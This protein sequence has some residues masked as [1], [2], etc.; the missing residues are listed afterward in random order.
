[1]PPRRPTSSRADSSKPSGGASKNDHTEL[2]PSPYYTSRARKS[3]P[4]PPVPDEVPEDPAAEQEYYTSNHYP[5]EG[6]EGDPPEGTPVADDPRVV[7]K[8]FREMDEG[9]E[10]PIEEED[11]D[12]PDSTR[13]GPPISLLVLEG[14]DAGKK[15]RFKSVRMVVGRGK[16]V[17]LKL[18][19]QAVSRRHLELIH[20]D[21]GT[22]MR[23]LGGASGTKVNDERV[24]EKL[25]KH[26][27]EIAIGR[28]LLRFVD[29]LE[30]VKQFQAE[31]DAKEAEAKKK[32]EE[33]AKKKEEEA[34]K[35]KEEAANA[36]AAGKADVDPNDPRLKE[37][38]QIRSVPD[39]MAAVPTRRGQGKLGDKKVLYIGGAGVFAVV[40][41]VVMIIF[42]VKKDPPAPPPID[43]KEQLAIVK[44]QAARNAIR[45]G[46]YAEA[47]K[48]IEDAERLKPGIDEEGLAK[49]A[50]AEAAVMEAFQAVRALM[51]EGNYQGARQKLEE[52]PPGTTA[53]S[54]E[55]RALLEKELTEAEATFYK[56]R[57]EELLAAN[58]LE[59]LRALIP[60]LPSEAQPLY[61]D[62][63][64]ELQEARA[65]EAAEQEKLE[66]TNKVLAAK[67]AAERRA[68]F[69]AEAF[70]AV[71]RK[72]ENGD[73]ERAVLEC[74]RVIEAHKGDDEIRE[75]AKSL[76]RLI[77]QF[78]RSF[79]DAQRKVQANSMETA[80]RPLKKS[81]ELYRQIGFKGA[82]LDAIR[83]QLAEAS[84]RAGKSALARNDIA[85][86]GGHF[87]EALR[88]N[89]GDSR[90]SEAL[91]NMQGKVNELYER[92]Y[93]EKDRDPRS[94]AEKFRIV[95]DT[96]EEG[97]ELREKA[98][99]Q[100]NELSP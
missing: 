12:N 6:E 42:I 99:A 39:G 46:E 19:D 37:G 71:E 83:E 38:T 41:L 50:Q 89:P 36:S 69:I 91:T 5:S 23:D 58:D 53:K 75:R 87:R 59:G 97:S 61:R 88:L 33:A 45:D 24:E 98:Q 1:M 92:A 51:T 63:L 30:A 62:K 93:I 84:V 40:M 28:T 48:L 29:E 20:G 13:A 68:Q 32:A 76:K 94:A 66:R 21:T 8:E 81:E 85:S 54:D 57:A 67:R 14:P 34:A 52:A 22:M 10:E 11:D 79:T 4:A 55:E 72:F 25:L 27:D 47:V 73:Y 49:A 56:K 70:D 80:V 17:D 9:G 7:S 43:P 15:K 60:K 64:A 16:D 2:K 26:G 95:I 44:L 3:R 90:A 77:P 18:S 100:L 78:A 35:K 74:D 31:Q 86:A 65:K 82:M 96:A